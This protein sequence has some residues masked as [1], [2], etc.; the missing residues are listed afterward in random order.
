MTER[1]RMRARVRESV[2]EGARGRA[3]IE[4]GKNLKTLLLAFHSRSY[5]LASCAA[6]TNAVDSQR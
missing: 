5:F 2:K 3:E 4:V 6:N 1:E